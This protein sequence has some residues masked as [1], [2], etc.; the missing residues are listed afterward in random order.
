VGTRQLSRAHEIINQSD[1]TIYIMNF[2]KL[3]K[4]MC[5]V[6]HATLIFENTGG[7]H[8]EHI[9]KSHSDI[10]FDYST[11]WGQFCNRIGQFVRN[12][13]R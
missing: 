9:R 4:I 7:I 8:I 5:K 12:T 2:F 11:L 6:L 3:K 1:Y 10:N 13:A